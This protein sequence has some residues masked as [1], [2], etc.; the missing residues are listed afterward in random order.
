MQVISLNLEN[1][2][3]EAIDARVKGRD[4][5]R[6]T[7]ASRD[8]ARYYEA[9]T[10]A[11]ADVRDKL[12]KAELSAVIDNLKGVYTSDTV[13]VRMLWANI[14][15]AL[16]NKLAEKWKIDGAALVRK[17]RS[18]TFI[19]SAALIDAA[20]RYWQAAGRDENPKIGDALEG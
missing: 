6:S 20:E 15:D 16:A 3:I 4:P 11:R 5:G 17:L 7:V 19:E 8:L 10:R 14:E 13:S 2:V 1:S 12:S 18:F 9:I